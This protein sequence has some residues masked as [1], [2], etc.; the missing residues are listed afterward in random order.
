MGF[1]SPRARASRSLR[2]DSFLRAGSFG[3]AVFAAVA[4]AIWSAAATAQQSAGPPPV[5]TLPSPSPTPAPLV[6][7]APVPTPAAPETQAAPGGA[8]SASDRIIGIRVVGYQTVAPDT[9][10]HYL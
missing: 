2:G 10:A 8:P 1:G 7:A 5:P 4:A 3:P 6:P 9:I